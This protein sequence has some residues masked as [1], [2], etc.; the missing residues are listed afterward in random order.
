LNE[1]TSNAIKHAFEGREEGMIK[2]SVE[3]TTGGTILT[4]VKDDGIGLPPKADIAKAETLGLK[5]VRNIVQR[6]L[7]GKMRIKR[8][9]GTEFIVEFKPL[10]KEVKYA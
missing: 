5:L 2:I 8:D 4:S 10:G 1:L 3:M 7:K 6:Q 9:R